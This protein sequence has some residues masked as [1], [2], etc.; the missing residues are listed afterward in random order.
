MFCRFLHR[1]GCDVCASNSFGCNAVLWS[2]QGAGTGAILAWLRECGVEFRLLNSNGHSALHK[3]AQRGCRETVEWLADAF[4]CDNHADGSLFVGPDAEGNCPSDLCGMEGHEKLAIWIAERECQY[5]ARRWSNTPMVDGSFDKP[6]IPSWLR[7]A[8]AK[9]KST[10]RPTL[11]LLDDDGHRWGSGGG[12]RRIV[13][14]MLLGTK[15]AS[16]STSKAVE[17]GPKADFD[18]ID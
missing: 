2:A 6:L 11:N 12:V 18:D 9:A 4:L 13:G 15:A 8:L 10:A 17:P 3:A 1:R 14:T 5:F 16:A 7:E